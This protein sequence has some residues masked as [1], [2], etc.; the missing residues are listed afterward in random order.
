MKASR[1]LLLF[2]IDG[3]IVDTAGAGLI[4]LLDGFHAAFPEHRGRAFPPLEL[5][6][7]T[8]HAVVMGLFEHFGL[9]DTPNH[10]AR[11]FECYTL[12]LEDH[13]RSFAGVGRGGLLPGVRN[14]L[15]AI[16][17]RH[18]HRLGVLTG[19]LR[20]GAWIKLRH[21]GIDRHFATGAFGDDHHDRNELGPIARRRA[22]K[23]FGED[24]AP[25]R[26]AVIGDTPRDIA[27][28][29]AFGAKAIAVATGSASREHLAAA[30]PDLLLEDFSNPAAV[31]AGIEGLFPSEPG[32]L[33]PRP[34]LE[35]PA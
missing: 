26:I 31:L 7:A 16:A 6:G 13:L 27:C 24:F 18:Q 2:D 23:A 25:G 20:E 11:F 4:S 33:G 9:P 17:S 3:T 1:T 30:A 8:D 14:L 28:A 29:R 22:R 34:G 5:G 10:R 12:R 32:S 35:G 15:E 21:F 19:N